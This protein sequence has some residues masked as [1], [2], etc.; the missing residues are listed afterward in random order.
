M[1]L[2]PHKH[3]EK[4]WPGWDTPPSGLITGAPPTELQ[5]QTGAG[6]GNWRRQFHG[7][8]SQVHG[9]E[10]VQEKGIFF[11]FYLSNS[12]SK[13]TITLLRIS[14]FDFAKF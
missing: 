14:D 12:L 4:V 11:F 7:I 13:Q 9:N 8:I 3:R 10:Y 2:G 5:G 1:A 6:R